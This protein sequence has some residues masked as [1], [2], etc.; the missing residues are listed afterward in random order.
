LR[1]YQSKFKQILH[2]GAKTSLPIPGNRLIANLRNA[3]PV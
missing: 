3:S 1:K 2:Y